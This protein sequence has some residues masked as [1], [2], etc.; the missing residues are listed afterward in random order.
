MLAVIATIPIALV[1]VLMVVLAWPA[2]RAMPIGWLAAG[3]I[4]FLAWDMPLT[5]IAASSL[6]GLINA[7]DILL[8][9]L[10]AILILQLMRRGGG[11]S[12]IS[13]S[14]TRVSVDRRV[15][16]ILIAWLMGSFLEGAAGFGTPAAVA[17]PLLV[18]L[19]FPALIAV[20][21]ALLADTTSVTFGAVGVP[22]WGGFAPLEAVV[23]LD[24][25][26][27]FRDYLLDISAYSGVLHFA[28]GTFV[29]LTIVV[30]TTKVTSGSFRKGLEIWPLAI[31]GGLVFTIPQAIVA[32]FVG[33][34]LPSLLGALIALPIFIV[35]VSRGFLVPR[36]PW[37]LPARQDW[38]EEWRGGVEPGAGKEAPPHLSTWR[39]W[40]PYILVGLALLIT[41]VPGLALAE[42]LQTWTVGWTQI[43][44][45]DLGYEIEPLYNPGI[46]PF[47]L[48]ALLI[49]FMHRMDRK[50][51][52]RAWKDAFRMIRPAAVALFFTLAMVYVMM[53][54]GEAADIDSMLIVMA[55]AAANLAGA[56]WYLFAPMVGIL[57]TFI[58]GSNT[59]SNIMFGVFQLS[60][61]NQAGLHEVPVLSLQAVGG[62]AG[63]PICIHNVVAVLATVGLIGK[64]GIV[65]RRNLPV[66]L[67]YGLLAGLTAWLLV[68]LFGG[69]IA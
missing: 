2:A 49:P 26:V 55:V 19:G 65:I 60:T 48:I 17:A 42:V 54:S 18:G 15:Q 45:T 10:G 20:M 16:I 61:A 6:E 46:V 68:L 41:R 33:P 9:V 50:S 47:L 7:I 34:E 5:W 24:P 38:P 56:V 63:N 22:I 27:T 30:L 40:F 21:V 53:N 59:V 32:I 62:A 64:E 36:E 67:L 12:V 8:I 52:G 44:G 43:L 39:A 1:A 13:D 69:T 66:V 23:D 4:A 51:V 28:V 58:S 3:I 31:F 37:D 35:A 11:M 25:Q 14:M 57:G 29:P